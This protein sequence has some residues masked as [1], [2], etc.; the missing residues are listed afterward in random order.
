MELLLAIDSALRR[1]T[2]EPSSRRLAT[3]ER[4][5]LLLANDSALHADNYLRHTLVDAAHQNSLYHLSASS[6]LETASRV[7]FN[8]PFGSVHSQWQYAA[9]LW[10]NSAQFSDP[11]YVHSGT[12]STRAR[13]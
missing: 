7:W 4:S 10:R 11:L 1:E 9:Q 2:R 8:R 5:V 3:M 12:A 6:L 13:R